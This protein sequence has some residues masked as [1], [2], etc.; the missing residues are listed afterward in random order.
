MDWTNSYYDKIQG[1]KHLLIVPNTEHLLVTGVLEIYAS[2]GTF[3]RS[4]AQ[5]IK[6]RPT[7][8]YSVDRVNGMI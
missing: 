6:K 7:F 5:G 2:M 4:L 1:E 3:I 8:D